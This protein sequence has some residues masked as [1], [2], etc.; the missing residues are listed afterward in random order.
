MTIDTLA[1]A[2]HLESAGIDR[3]FAEAHAEAMN[4][5][6]FPQL[7]TKADLDHAVIELSNRM[8]E[9]TVRIVFVV[10]A[11]AGLAVTVAKLL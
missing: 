11:A 7:V 1:F 6:V 9:L 10:I 4:Q 5:H 8:S 2:K 3:K